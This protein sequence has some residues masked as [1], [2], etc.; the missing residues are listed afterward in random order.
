[1]RIQRNQRHLRLDERRILE[2]LLLV[3]QIVHLLH[4]DGDSFVGGALQVQIERGVDFVR[5]RLEVIAREA[6]F[7]IVRSAGPQS[8]EH[9]STRRR[10]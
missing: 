10:R 7:Q 3:H 5:M 1:M 8:R 2:P 6:L 4:T 9:R